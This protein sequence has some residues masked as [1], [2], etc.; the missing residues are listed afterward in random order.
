V[1]EKEVKKRV[2]TC[3]VC[4]RR[5]SKGELV[6]F[7]RSSNGQVDIDLTGRANG[8]GAYICLDIKCFEKGLKNKALSRAFKMN[9]SDFDYERLKKSFLEIG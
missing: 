7:V 5:D 8:R 6:R 3:C 2:R 9:I 4:G 1:S